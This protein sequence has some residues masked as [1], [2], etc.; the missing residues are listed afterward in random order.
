MRSLFTIH[1]GEYLVGSYIEKNFPNFKV[2]IPSKDTGIDLLITN[3]SNERTVSLQVKYS[4]DFLVTHLSKNHQEKLSACGWWTLNK[5]KIKKSNANFWV[6]VLQ[7]FKGKIFH[8]IVIE[9]KILLKRLTKIHGNMKIFQS[10]LWVTNNNKCWEARGLKKKEQI[11][12]INNEYKNDNR[13]F[14]EYLNCW[15]DVKKYLK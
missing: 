6:F 5:E 4:K 10:Y 9:P 13:N 12:L 1:A 14:S 3:K 2:W 8:H 15:V 7:D 11:L